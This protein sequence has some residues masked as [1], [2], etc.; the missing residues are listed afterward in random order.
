V[1]P[2]AVRQKI[3][4]Y[5]AT[6]RRMDA[7]AWAVLFAE[8][9]VVQDPVGQPPMSGHEALR[10]FHQNAVQSIFSVMDMREEHVFAA[11][12]EAAVK[13]TCTATAHTGRVVTFEGIS[14]FT[15]DD[16]GA[17]K[18]MRAFWDAIAMMTALQ[19]S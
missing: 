10:Q 13:W 8:D 15:F 12:N 3:T 1:T 9:G 14:I 2:D 5:Y 6:V 11:Q 4:D 17:I 7:A 19:G 16:S 18:L